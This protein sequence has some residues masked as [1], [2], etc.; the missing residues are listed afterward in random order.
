MAVLLKEARRRFPSKYVKYLTHSLRCQ[1]RYNYHLV[2]TQISDE[3]LEMLKPY[4]TQRATP[5]SLFDLYSQCSDLTD[6]SRLKYAQFI[7]DELPIRVAHRITELTNLPYNL[8]LMPSIQAV[9]ELY[10]EN[11]KHMINEVKRPE[12]VEDDLKYVEFVQ[13]HLERLASVI[14]MVAQGIREMREYS[15]MT[16]DQMHECPFINDFLDRF[17]LSRVG[18]RVLTAQYVAI[19]KPAQPGSVGIIDTQLSPKQVILRAARDAAELCTRHYG[20]AP[21]VIVRDDQGVKFKYLAG[22]LQHMVFELLKNSMR[23]TC[24]QHPGAFDD[25]LPPTVV[26]VVPGQTENTIKISDEGGGI[27]RDSI[28]KIWLYSYTTAPQSSSETTSIGQA[29]SS[30]V[31][32]GYGYGLPLSRLYARYF[33]GDLK[34]VSMDGYGTDAYLYLSKLGDAKEPLGYPFDNPG[35][36]QPNPGRRMGSLD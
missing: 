13:D 7:W 2:G 21:E 3:D 8:S 1:K 10:I 27:A 4:A 15:G 18:T 19:H 16:E 36:F 12:T 24:E 25:D 29:N 34:I 28:D 14:P 5:T 33:G 17:F 30:P 9:R 26:V 23:A 22:H 35:F 6:Q 32:A 20:S 31:F 11:F